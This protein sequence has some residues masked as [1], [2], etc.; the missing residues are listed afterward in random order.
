MAEAE[1]DAHAHIAMPTAVQTAASHRGGYTITVDRQS[2]VGMDLNGDPTR[3]F[4][5][6]QP[7]SSSQSTAH[8]NTCPVMRLGLSRRTLIQYV[9]CQWE[10][11]QLAKNDIIF[12]MVI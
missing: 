10:C 5:M 9:N 7:L 11:L 2:A 6:T 4:S 3:R 1:G 12:E 8:P